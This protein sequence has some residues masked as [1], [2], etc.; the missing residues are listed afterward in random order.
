MPFKSEAQKRFMYARHPDIAE[1]WQK[2]GKGY[3][4]QKFGVKT[5]GTTVANNKP[6][7]SAG[8][9]SGNSLNSHRKMDDKKFG[10]IERRMKKLSDSKKGK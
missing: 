4:E 3:V 10:A 5:S 6:V 8:N 7:G 1:R 2:E 9:P